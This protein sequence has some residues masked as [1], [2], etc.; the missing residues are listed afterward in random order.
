MSPERSSINNGELKYIEENLSVLTQL[1]LQIVGYV[2]IVLFMSFCLVDLYMSPAYFQRFLPYRLSVSIILLILIFFIRRTQ[3]LKYLY[4]LMFI[5]IVTSAVTIEIISMSFS[6]H[7]YFYYSGMYLAVIGILGFIPI[8]PALSLGVIGIVYATFVFPQLIFKHID[9]L[10]F[11]LLNAYLF[12]TSVIAFVWRYSHQRDLLQRLSLQ[13]KHL[14]DQEKLK[15]YS[16]KLEELVMDQDKELRNSGIILSTLINNANDGIIITDSNG[17]I[18]I[19]NKSACKIYDL[20]NMVGTNI[21]DLEIH[22]YNR[23]ELLSYL[24]KGEA[25]LFETKRH[26]KDGS[27]IILEV[28]GNLVKIGNKAIMQLFC[29]DITERKKMQ[30]KLMYAQK[31]EALGTLAGCIAHDFKNVLATMQSFSELILY[32][33]QHEPHGTAL[34]TN[35]STHVQI[36][37]NEI[38]QASQL[39]TKL[40]SFGRKEKL[41]LQP[42]D[43][44]ELSEYIVDLF[45]SLWQNNIHISSSF[46]NSIPEVMG[47]R[48]QFEQVLVNLFINAKDA[49]P[50]GGEI[51]ISTELI[52]WEGEPTIETELANGKYVKLSIKD[53]G[54]GIADKNLSHI[55]EPFFTTKTRAAEPGTGLGLAMVYGIVREHGGHIT[56]K[57]KLGQGTTF[58]IYLPVAEN[59]NSFTKEGYRH[60]TATTE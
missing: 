10:S 34:A 31:M 30:E 28:S 11:L 54:V 49:M 48:S 19:A 33:N 21:E 16:C 26:K 6:A 13:Y 46:D 24:L 29:R 22:A 53:S 1:W 3:N 23:E 2:T 4:A 56:V 5:G 8:G 37:R 38:Q 52:T 60:G 44:N 51:V 35:M 58:D 7:K 9:E 15:E 32:S 55:F 12:S 57:S 25:L 17:L 14:N 39:L 40:L 20:D 47:E 59:S 43:V 42:F 27:K 45:S 36:I 18:T 50:E 41:V